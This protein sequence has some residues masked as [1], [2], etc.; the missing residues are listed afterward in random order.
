LRIVWISHSG[1]LGG[2]E[3]ALVETVKGLTA[4]GTEVH[5]IVPTHGKLANLLEA[6]G[7]T[8]SVIPCAWWVSPRMT[9]PRAIRHLYYNL[10]VGP[11]DT[12]RVLRKTSPN[13]VIT[14]TLTV[15]FGAFAAKLVGIPHVWYIHEFLTEDHGLTFDIGTSFSLFLV[16]K[17]SV[18]VIVTSQAV[19]KKFQKWI[20]ADK[21]R[22][23]YD[24]VDVPAVSAK[25][26]EGKGDFRL[27]LVGR[28]T[29]SKRQEDAIR[30]VHLLVGKGLN[31]RLALVGDETPDYGTYL[32]KLV[33][34]LGVQKQVDFISFTDS[35][36]SYVVD[37]DVALMCS[38]C[39]AFGRV[40]I[41]AMKQGKPVIG[42]N[43][44]GT[45]EIIKDGW[46]GYLYE[47]ENYADLAKKIEILYQ[48][49]ET[50]MQMGSRAQEWALSTFN[51]NNYTTALLS[52]F[53]EILC[54][55]RK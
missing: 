14:N 45:A 21:M 19:Y 34:G 47:P 28:K 29:W 3:L 25:T 11:M 39:E 31:V 26:R 43:S 18:R 52:L 44:G 27:V 32:H 40:T 5:V 2:T 51:L 36:C 50:A 55:S 53:E 10:C 9:F 8:I 17:L 12:A 22:V 20:P 41:E 6:N 23:I 49:R 30:A 46:N 48:N 7:A 15:P 38:K 35:P 13:L 54:A 33:E 24:G 37:S 4:R 16:N 1:G 42:A